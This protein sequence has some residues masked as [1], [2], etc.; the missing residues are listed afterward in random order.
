MPSDRQFVHATF[1]TFAPFFKW[2]NG[3]S[4][5]Q[6]DQTVSAQHAKRVNDGVLLVRDILLDE[7]DQNKQNEHVKEMPSQPVSVFGTSL[8]NK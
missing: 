6:C 7:Y 1:A 4:L 3:N 5:N 2:A 8:L